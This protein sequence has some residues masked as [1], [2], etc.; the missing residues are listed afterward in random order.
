MKSKIKKIWN[1]IWQINFHP[2]SEWEIINSESDSI[3]LLLGE[4]IF[5]I[6]FTVALVTF[7]GNLIIMR[8]NSYTFLYVFIKTLSV[9]CI[10]FFTFYVSL[11]I[12]YE[13]NLK[14]GLAKDYRKIF[15]LFA[16]SFSIFWTALVISGIFADY[17]TLGSFLKFL[18]LIGIYPFWVG[19]DILLNIPVEKKNKFFLLSL[20]VVLIVYFLIDWSFGFAL[21][22]VYYAGLLT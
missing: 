1:R 15:K 2:F 13:I 5:P 9:F 20:A 4:F 16:Y 10:S 7:A 18:G 22:A 11:L 8:E 17:K 14:L 21:R 3:S 19:L 12:V 6:I